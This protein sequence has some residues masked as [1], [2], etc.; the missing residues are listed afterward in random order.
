M[1]IEG[2]KIGGTYCRSQANRGGSTLLIQVSLNHFGY[3][4]TF[5][6]GIKNS[7]SLETAITLENELFSG[8]SEPECH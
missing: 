3:F 5:P 2:Q 7:P 8:H 4:I 1:E 6:S